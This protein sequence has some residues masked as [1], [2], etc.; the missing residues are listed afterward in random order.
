MREHSSRDKA[1]HFLFIEINAVGCGQ[2]DIVFSSVKESWLVA[3]HVLLHLSV[4][5]FSPCE[6]NIGLIRATHRHPG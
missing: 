3:L 4:S 1:S 6:L 2:A 5:P